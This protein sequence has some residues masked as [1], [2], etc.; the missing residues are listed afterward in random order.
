MLLLYF[1]TAGLAVFFFFHASYHS[2][3]HTFW[4][5]ITDRNNSSELKLNN[6]K[7][8]HDRENTTNIQ[9]RRGQQGVLQMRPRHWHSVAHAPGVCAAACIAWECIV[10]IPSCS[11]G[12]LFIHISLGLSVVLNSAD[13]TPPPVD[14]C[15][16]TLSRGLPTSLD[17]LLHDPISVLLLTV[18]SIQMSLRIQSL[19]LSSDFL[20]F[21]G[22]LPLTGTC[23]GHLHLNRREGVERHSPFPD[24]LCIQ[25]MPPRSLS[26]PYNSFQA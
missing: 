25:L 12:H 18:P 5:T 22:N 1:Y 24:S 15:D 9:L 26:L 21:S 17:V 20:R 11:L 7:E 13:H 16:T 6:R 14:F 8:G 4:S 19:A 2:F 23:P 10:L 3:K